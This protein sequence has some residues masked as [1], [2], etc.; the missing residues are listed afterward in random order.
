MFT[1]ANLF[2]GYACVIYA[3]RAHATADPI[4]RSVTFGSAAVFI[5]VA[6]LVDMLD[7]RIARMT[8][9]TS[10]FGMELDSLADIVSFG[11]APAI[12]AFAWGL[13]PLGRLGWAGAFLYVTCAALRLARFNVQ[14]GSV[15]KRYFVGMP[16]PAAAAVIATT[17]FFWP[18]GLTGYP[19]LV[20]LAVLALVL[21]PGFL[22]VSTLRFR[23][24]KSVADGPRRPYR[25]L[26]Q[27][28]V[29]IAAVAVEPPLVLLLMAYAYLLS[30]FVEHGYAR[31]R[32][33]T[34]E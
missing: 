6:A 33:R 27:I 18:E 12:L 28:A 29:V 2:C 16:S 17:V 23:A 31:I 13:E 10:E 7:G 9:T 32:R 15:D 3:M 26:L 20:R 22:M 34:S 30:A 19:Q 25:K 5:G 8:G 11:L 4:A 24:F 14:A 21:V 1:M